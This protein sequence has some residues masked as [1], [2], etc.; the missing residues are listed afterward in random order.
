MVFCC[1]KNCNTGRTTAAFTDEFADAPLT[2]LTV[3]F[4]DGAT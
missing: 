1:S 4:A 3:Q 2:W